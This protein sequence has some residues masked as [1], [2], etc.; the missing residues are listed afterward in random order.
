MEALVS[1]E[2]GVFAKFEATVD[3]DSTTVEEVE[4]LGDDESV[5]ETE[6]DEGR[7]TEESGADRGTI[8]VLNIP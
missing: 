8:R 3:V 1:D 2:D 4:D 7:V 6:T 5:D